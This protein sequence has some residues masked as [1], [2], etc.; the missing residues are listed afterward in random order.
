MAALVDRLADYA[1][2]G[3]SVFSSRR[4][5]NDT[6]SDRAKRSIGKIL[7]SSAIHQAAVD[8][9]RFVIQAVRNSKLKNLPCMV[10][11]DARHNT[12]AWLTSQIHVS[13]PDGKSGIMEVSATA[14]PQ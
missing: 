7:R 13:F 1:V 8:R 14:R 9:E 12:V 5:D 4:S 6:L 2:Y 3:Q 11:E 10:R